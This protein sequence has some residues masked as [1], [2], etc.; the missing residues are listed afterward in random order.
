MRPETAALQAD[1][2]QALTTR[3][4]HMHDGE[5][6]GSCLWG[7]RQ[8]PSRLESS[9]LSASSRPCRLHESIGS[10]LWGCM[11]DQ[12]GKQAGAAQPQTKDRIQCFVCL[13]LRLSACLQLQP[14]SLS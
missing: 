1:K 10:Q 8:L 3:T 13:L 14:R 2:L 12:K 5:R 4:R 7:Q 6:L 9:R 11:L